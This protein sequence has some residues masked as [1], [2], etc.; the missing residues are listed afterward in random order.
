MAASPR[1]PGSTQEWIRE[2]LNFYFGGIELK[3]HNFFGK[4]AAGRV[5]WSVVLP[6]A[7]AFPVS[8]TAATQQQCDVLKTLYRNSVGI[9]I[10]AS[11]QI[12]AIVQRRVTLS[13]AALALQIKYKID[14]ADLQGILDVAEQMGASADALGNGF[15]ARKKGFD[16]SVTVI[17]AL[18]P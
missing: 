17:R 6:A 1:E 10:T 14:T 12:T 2:R 15:D 5:F 9:E 18:C 13:A 8:A 3:S 16:D 4:L 7:I 11:E